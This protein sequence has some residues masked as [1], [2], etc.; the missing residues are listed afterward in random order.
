LLGGG[1]APSALQLQQSGPT[2]ANYI[3]KLHGSFSAAHKD[4]GWWL[5]S[6]A[7]SCDFGVVTLTTVPT[8]GRDAFLQLD[9]LEAALPLGLA[10]RRGVALEAGLHGRF[11]FS[12]FH[13]GTSFRI[14]SGLRYQ[15][16]VIPRRADRTPGGDRP[17]SVSS[18]LEEK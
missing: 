11:D 7:A 3:L 1:H 8:T 13:D 10:G 2:S 6:R 15:Q 4:H 16:A 9:D 18:L 17:L 12:W 5:R 14:D